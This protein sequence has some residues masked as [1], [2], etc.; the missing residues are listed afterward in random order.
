MA[1]AVKAVRQFGA[2]VKVTLDLFVPVTGNTLEEALAD[3]L[4]RKPYECVEF[5]NGVDYN[6]GEIELQG[7]HRR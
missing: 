7:V 6:D 3:A 5:P 4:T 2:Y 1:K